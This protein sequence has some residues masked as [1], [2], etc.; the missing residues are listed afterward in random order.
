MNYLYYCVLDTIF[1]VTFTNVLLAFS[2]SCIIHGGVLQDRIS[3]RVVC[4]NM[5]DGHC[6]YT[7]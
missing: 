4:G 1:K 2:C 3:L 7:F 5:S 6:P